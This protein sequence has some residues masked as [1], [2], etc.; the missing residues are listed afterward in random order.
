MFKTVDDL[1]FYE[2]KK[3]GLWEVVGINEIDAELNRKDSET[4]LVIVGSLG[5]NDNI[6]EDY[7]RSLYAALQMCSL[8]DEPIHGFLPDFLEGRIPFGVTCNPKDIVE[9]SPKTIKLQDSAYSV[10]VAAQISKTYFQN[11]YLYSKLRLY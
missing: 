1:N 8:M 11:S 2:N 7:L 3:T 10:S 6:S 5:N 4:G 9:I